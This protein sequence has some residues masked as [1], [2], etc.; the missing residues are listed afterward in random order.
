VCECV[1]V[2]TSERQSVGVCEGVVTTHML[3]RLPIVA[4]F[5]S[6]PLIVTMT[7]AVLVS[8]VREGVSDRSRKQVGE[9]ASV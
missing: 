9:G 1:S 6:P 4:A 2:G 8:P 7:G 3:R 5:R